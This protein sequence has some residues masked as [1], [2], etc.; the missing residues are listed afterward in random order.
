MDE[1]IDCDLDVALYYRQNVKKELKRLWQMWI[2]SRYKQSKKT[3]DQ[4]TITKLNTLYNNL[5]E[6]LKEQG[7]TPLEESRRFI[8]IAR[9]KNGAKTGMEYLD[10]YIGWLRSGTV[11]RLSGYANTGKSRFMYRVAI[12]LLRQGKSVHIFSLEVPKGLVLINL[13]AA[14]YDLR[15]NDVEYGR[16]EKELTEFYE[17]YGDKVAI[18]DDKYSLPEIHNEIKYKNKDI[19]MID[20]VQNVHVDGKS[21]YEKMTTVAQEIQKMAIKTKKPFFDLSQVSN[22]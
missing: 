3:L 15:T 22:E 21:E 13:V 5:D 11:T 10:K 4:D 12:N 8:E 18:E 16:H 17:K 1:M 14:F 9:E 2:D 19:V 6:Q 7:V 20:Y